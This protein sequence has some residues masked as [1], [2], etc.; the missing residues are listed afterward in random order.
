[1]RFLAFLNELTAP[2]PE[3]D[4]ELGM[5]RS[6]EGVPDEVAFAATPGQAIVFSKG[7]VPQH[8]GE[9]V[10]LLR[11]HPATVRRW[12]TGTGAELGRF[13]G[14]GAR[15]W[16]FAVSPGGRRAVTIG[17]AGKLRVWDVSTGRITLEL[18]GDFGEAKAALFLPDGARCAIACGRILAG[19]PGEAAVRDNH[20]VR[21]WDIEAGREVS[22]F[23][24]HKD[25]PVRLAVSADGGLILSSSEPRVWSRAAREGGSATLALWR[26]ADGSEVW[27]HEV[28]RKQAA[29]VALMPDGAHVVLGGDDGA[30]RLRRGDD[31]AVVREYKNPGKATGVLSL[32][33]ASNGRR[34][35]AGYRDCTFRVWDRETGEPLAVHRCHV[36]PV[37]AIAVSSDGARALTASADATA[38]LWRL[39]P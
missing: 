32:A 17:S 19:A 6:L 8:K 24:G 11:R 2:E 35:L 29:A 5:L 30:I 4:L 21:I 27:R 34:I 31:L 13:E 1:M 12:D 20:V 22:R 39:P 3:P 18:D 7:Y 26:V 28:E 16:A 36:G 23:E 14:M 38:R 9:E 33:V 25:P 15:V 37:T 10:D